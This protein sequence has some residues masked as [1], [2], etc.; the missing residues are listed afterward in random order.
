M[1]T[2]AVLVSLS[3]DKTITAKQGKVEKQKKRKKETK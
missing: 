1:G 3:P 2:L